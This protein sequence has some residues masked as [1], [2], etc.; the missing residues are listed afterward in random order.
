MPDFVITSTEA[1]PAIPFSGSKLFVVI[2]TSWM[3]S[4]GGTYS[5]PPPG[6]QRKMLCAPSMRVE[7]EDGSK[8]FT[9]IAMARSGVSAA[10]PVKP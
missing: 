2:F 3:A 9:G 6:F 10:A 7:F 8:P 4:I 1:A 5:V